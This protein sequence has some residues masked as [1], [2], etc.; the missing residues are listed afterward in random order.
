MN[1]WFLG[2]FMTVF[3]AL[4][5]AEEGSLSFTPPVS[6]YSVI[7]LGNIFGIVDGVLHGTG[8][9]MMGSM[10]AVFNAAVLALGGMVIMYT[11][12]VSTMNTA[13]EGQIMGQKWSSIWIP[14][15]S[16][17]GLAMLIPKASGYC[18]M[19]IFVMWIVVQGIGAADKVWDAALNYLNRGGVIIQAQQNPTKTLTQSESAGVAGGAQAILAGQVCMIALEQQLVKARNNYTSQKQSNSG[20]CAG[21]PSSA[22]SQFCD[23]VVPNFLNSVNV[24]EIQRQSGGLQSK[25]TAP[26]PNFEQAPYSNLNGICGH[27]AWNSFTLNEAEISKITTLSAGDLE[28]AKMSRAIAIQQMYMDLSTVAQTMVN[29]NVAINPETTDTTTSNFSS[30]AAQPYGLPRT[31]TGE[32]C[33]NSTTPNCTVWGDVDKMIPLFGGTEFQGAL[34][35]YYG[36]ML[37]TLNLIYQAKN[38][39]NADKSRAFIQDAKS[40][41]WIMAGSYFF[42]L[43]IL[44]AQTSTGE[45]SDQ[46]TG[47]ENS[48]YNSDGLL[49]D[50]FGGSGGSCSGK[51]ST[52]CLW[53]N[54]DRSNVKPIVQMIDGAGSESG[55]IPTPDLTPGKLRSVIDGKNSATVYGFT[56]NASI[57]QLPGEPGQQPLTF[58]SLIRISVPTHTYQLP[59]LN[60]SCN[61]TIWTGCMGRWLGDIFY[62]DILRGVMN[63]I[64]GL[65]NQV[66]MQVIMTFLALPLQGIALIFK[67]GVSII[68]APGVNPIVALANMGTYYI[69]FAAELWLMIL[70]V[71]L[72]A[73]LIPIFGIFIFAILAILG[74]LV[75]AWVGIMLTIG[76]VTAYYVPV[77]PYMIFTFGS[78]AWLMSVIEAMVAAPIVALGVTHPEGH[79]A[80]GK[81]EQAIMILLNV[82]LRPSMMIIGYIAAIALSYVG[83]WILNAG[84]DQ[85]IGFIQGG[86]N[87]GT[88]T[89]NVGSE[90][91]SMWQDTGHVVTPA[92][93]VSGGYTGW[94]GIFAFFFSI[95]VYTTMYLTIVQKAFGLI[96]YLPDKVLRWIGGSPE[97]LGQEA[98]GWTEETKKVADEGAKATQGA[99]AAMDKQLAGGI[100]QGAAEAQKSGGG[101]ASA[102][103][104]KSGGGGGGGGGGAAGGGAVPPG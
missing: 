103:G 44:N 101:E 73:S 91:S 82:F 79:D 87:F 26:M 92:G 47:L 7:F 48:T 53:L 51:F 41:G 4:A 10:F 27:I 67:E 89:A 85:A 57:L 76:F 12:L 102:E 5:L 66:I 52:L 97:S 59:S 15:R 28:T 99:M 78:I 63:L 80:F 40:Q 45:L 18:M 43:A 56:N 95:L 35:D 31:V 38:N 42:N 69:N 19:Q 104:G 94:A 60:F 50:A 74:P 55:I 13:H 20:P 96:S 17:I 9:Q 71:S 24:V 93:G 8:S 46:N 98:A 64:L 11:L 61:G 81:G 25:L 77:L 21:T 83:V 54:Q 23:T 14:F 65:V 88:G 84:F 86:I 58:D 32:I 30:V 62:N 16:T 29:N 70:E 68:S 33:T 72:I 6:D 49:N 100:G 90:I 1:K 39:A 75:A 22:M 34:T 36:I 2:F 37:P 3:P